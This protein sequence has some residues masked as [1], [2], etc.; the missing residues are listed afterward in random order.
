MAVPGGLTDRQRAVEDL[1]AGRLPQG[2]LVVA[3]G[4]GAD[5]AVCAWAA[6]RSGAR[7]RTLTVDHGQAASPVLLDA[8]RATAEMLGLA[9][10][11]VPAP[12]VAASEVALREARYRALEGALSGGEV[13]LTGHTA[14]DQ[15][16][17]VLGNLLRGAGATGLAGIPEVRGRVHRP[18]LGITRREARAVA[19]E[20]RLPYADDPG[21]L[22]PAVRRNVLRHRVLPMVEEEVSPGA[23]RA[24][25]RAGRLLGADDRLLEDRAARFPVRV[26]EDGTRLPAAALATLPGPVAG[27]L[28][29]R[30][31]RVAL[32]PYPGTSRD[33]SAV[34]DVAAGTA[35][36]RS[37]S[38][39][40][41][42]EREGP[43]VVLRCGSAPVP[44]PVSLPVPG[45]AR[46]G[47]WL[48]TA[49]ERP[50]VPVPMPPGRR[51]ALLGSVSAD[52]LTVRAVVSGDRVALAGGSKPAAEALREGGVPAPA[53]R[54]WP[55]VCSGER[56]AW[57]VGCR[58]AAWAAAGPA[59][60]V[61]MLTA[62]EV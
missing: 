56:I 28:A 26:A 3:L 4:G 23:R 16:E 52:G 20:L 39:G 30:G 37:L 6:A 42:A 62:R 55:V 35:P 57:V 61:T 14:D 58:T 45:T 10:D 50:A 24:L 25:A 9:H 17:T 31:L 11:V 18:L 22:D 8:A 48:L 49:T 53:R 1:V 41:T 46:F 13:L 32:A 29:R 21:N 5:S 60:P 12:V 51:H 36:R 40:R 33:V 7:V 54:G 59:G 43:W 47:S 44:G 2:P 34:L 19:D 38:R 27:R 15:A